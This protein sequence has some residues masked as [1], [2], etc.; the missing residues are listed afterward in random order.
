MF[1]NLGFNITIFQLLEKE[2]TF[3]SF[4][5]PPCSIKHIVTRKAIRASFI[6]F[7][8]VNVFMNGF[9]LMIPGSFYHAVC[10]WCIRSSEPVF[11]MIGFA[12]FIQ[13]REF[14]AELSFLGFN[15]SIRKFRSVIG[16]NMRNFKREKIPNTDS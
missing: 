6:L 8:Y 16:Q 9:L 1:K 2:F 10:F 4:L 3:S 12:D 11:N 7:I 13:F 14:P 15:R 5:T